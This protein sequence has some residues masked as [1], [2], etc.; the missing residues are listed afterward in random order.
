MVLPF[1]S[2]IY[3]QFT[4]KD[5]H[6][7]TLRFFQRISPPLNQIIAQSAWNESAEQQKQFDIRFMG[8]GVTTSGRSRTVS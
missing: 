7:M 2:F 3:L 8:V 6:T 5:R 4:G 1:A